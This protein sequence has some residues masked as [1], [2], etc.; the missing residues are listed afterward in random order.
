MFGETC[1]S[2]DLLESPEIEMVLF[3][4]W[5]TLIVVV[6][7]VLMITALGSVVMVQNKLGVGDGLGDGDGEGLGDGDGDGD[8]DG[9][10]LGL[11]CGSSDPNKPSSS[12]VGDAT[13]LAA[14]DALG[15][16][17]ASAGLEPEIGVGTGVAPAA[18][19]PT[20]K[21]TF[22]T[23]SSNTRLLIVMS[24]EP[25]TSTET[26]SSLVRKR[27]ETWAFGEVIPLTVL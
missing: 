12:G 27:I 19:L 7:S 4:V 22:G 6:D 10:G 25:V 11:E 9:L 3:E 15:D 14:G 2:D 17:A 8:G 13:T 24:P 26:V 5:L 23:A 21:L 16:A 20:C 1:R 18:R